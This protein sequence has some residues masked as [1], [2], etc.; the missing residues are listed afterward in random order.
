MTT[1]RL[2]GISTLRHRNFLRRGSGAGLCQH[3]L[4]RA[5]GKLQPDFPA[6]PIPE[7]VVNGFVR[8]CWGQEHGTGE[9]P[10]IQCRDYDGIREV[11]DQVADQRGILGNVPALK[12]QQQA[13]A[14]IL[15][16]TLGQLLNDE[17]KI[18]P[19]AH[20][21]SVVENQKGIRRQGRGEVGKPC[22]I[23]RKM[24]GHPANFRGQGIGLAEFRPG[25]GKILWDC[26][27]QIL[28]VVV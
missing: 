19:P 5:Q 25:H 7:I 11:A 14:L 21:D 15:L 3:Q 24:A 27:G 13:T 8:R 4:L 18:L 16:Q 1:Q 12:V 2:M 10:G 22:G 28:L 9:I 23:G 20:G 26:H 17:G 6:L